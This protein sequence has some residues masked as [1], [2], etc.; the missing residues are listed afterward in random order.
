MTHELDAVGAGGLGSHPPAGQGSAEPRAPGRHW[1][2]LGVAGLALVL[3]GTA[4]GLWLTAGGGIGVPATPI[5]L[6]PTVSAVGAFVLWRRPGNRFGAVIA[7]T[8][9]WFSLI[10]LATATLNFAVKH[11][12]LPAVVQ[13]AALA[14]AWSAPALALPWTILV[15]WFPDGRFTAPAWRRA[16]AVAVVVASLVSMAGYLFGPPGQLP[17]IL[18]G[19]AIPAGLGGPF[20]AADRGF[21]DSLAVVLLAFPLVALLGLLGRYR[22]SAPLVRQQIRWLLA[23]TAMTVVGSG[24]AAGLEQGPDALFSIGVVLSA[25]VQ[26]LPTLAVAVAILRYRLWDIDVVV[27]RALVTA[28]LWALLSVLFVVPALASGLLVGGSGTLAA[29]AAALT[30]TL[31]FQPVRQ[32]TERAVEARV[33]RARRRGAQQ[34][35]RFGEALRT[36]VDVNELGDRLATTVRD[37]LGVP[38]AAFWLHLRTDGGAAL[39]VGGTAGIKVADATVLSREQADRLLSQPQ[40]A[41]GTTL[42]AELKQLL[43]ADT[44]MTIPL[45]AGQELVGLVACGERVGEPFTEGDLQLLT[46]FAGECALGLRSL[47]LEA[48]LRA[49]LTEIEDQ[50]EELRVSRQRLVA[51]QD[52]ER[53]RIE[54]NLH[55]GAQQQLVNLVV[56]IRELAGAIDPGRRGA[57]EQVAGEAEDAVFALQDLARGIFPS[58]LTDQGLVAA[59]RNHAGRL[60]LAVHVEI[61]PGLTGRRFAPEAEA[62]LYFV[63]LE[64]LTNVQKHAPGARASIGLHGADDDRHLVLEVRDDGPG[65]PD[66]RGGEGSGLQNMRDRM[67]AVGGSL[68][69]SSEPGAGTWVRARL[70]LPAAVVQLHR[71]EADS[72]R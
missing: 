54:R 17:A 22:R 2:P 45:V 18:A 12:G 42:P 33:Y 44:A 32:R 50:A 65:L 30:V 24:A 70:L 26:P 66:Q 27:S 51:V 67:A 31:L 23:A 43:P 39:R 16:F 36:A 20:A 3:L 37:G 72:R 7:G 28:V 69:I 56:R 48:E 52:E 25:V 68:D 21:I 4:A 15:L 46:R 60:P 49:K 8:G 71:A 35:A 59:L 1:R 58:V 29:V 19:S 64:A 47:R 9:L 6:A 5:E 13:Q 53:R 38:W 63:A 61:Q 34:M 62:A 10:T 14:V 57:W 41:W 55:D 11:P 40:V